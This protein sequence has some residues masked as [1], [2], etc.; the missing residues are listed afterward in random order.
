MIIY[1]I[2]TSRHILFYLLPL[3]LLST[4]TFRPLHNLQPLYSVIHFAGFYVL[5]IA[6]CRFR[7]QTWLSNKAVIYVLGVGVLCLMLFECQTDQTILNFQNTVL[8]GHLL[9]NLNALQKILFCVLMM[10]LLKQMQENNLMPEWVSRA[11]SLVAEYSFG[12]FFVHYYICNGPAKGICS[13]DIARKCFHLFWCQPAAIC[14][15][16]DSIHNGNFL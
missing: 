5:G 4:F 7:D 6:A 2:A 8:Q 1:D 3:L 14:H 10:N 9:V 15:C 16:H 12:I 13:P 11:F